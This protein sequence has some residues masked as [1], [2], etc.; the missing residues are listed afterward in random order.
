MQEGQTPRPLHEKATTKP[1][2][3]EA[4]RALPNP[5]QRM[6]QVRYDRSS[7]STCA[8]TGCSATARV[9]IGPCYPSTTKAFAHQ[10]PREFLQAT[11]TEIPL[12]IF[13]IGGITPDRL[14]DLAALGIHRVAVTAAVTAAADPAQAVREFLARLPAPG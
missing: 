8:E 11:A 4:Q 3:H 1:C 12:P 10:A 7:R 2:P 9:S 13:A 6:P 5:K 14:G